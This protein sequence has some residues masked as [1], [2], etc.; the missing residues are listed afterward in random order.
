[1]GFFQITI[2]ATILSVAAVCAIWEHA[3]TFTETMPSRVSTID[4]AVNR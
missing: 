1:M 3:D 2:V 4:A